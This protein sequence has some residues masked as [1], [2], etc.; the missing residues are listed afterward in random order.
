MKRSAALIATACVAAMMASC[1]ANVSTILP[2]HPD[3][4]SALDGQAYDAL[5]A[6]NAAITSAEQQVQ[7]GNLPAAKWTPLI[8]D[9]IRAY[10]LAD[11]AWVNYRNAVKAGASGQPDQLKSDIQNMN[12]A[13]GALTKG[14]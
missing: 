10:D 12:G 1:T 6:A 11:S 13:V 4:V 9:A 2:P 5:L 14:K 7:K 3:Q 8:N